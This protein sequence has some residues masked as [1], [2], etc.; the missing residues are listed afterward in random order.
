[1]GAVEVVREGVQI[2]KVTEP[3]VVFGEFSVLLDQ[4]HTAD[5]RALEASWF[6]RRRCGHPTQHW[7]EFKARAIACYKAAFGTDESPS[8]SDSRLILYRR[9]PQWEA[10]NA[11]KVVP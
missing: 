10:N 4:P 6:S 3:G 11:K 2:A 8:H 9:N 7:P 5:L 1:M